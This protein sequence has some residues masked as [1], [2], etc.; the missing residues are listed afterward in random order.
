MVR[1]GADRRQ[2]AGTLDIDPAATLIYLN[3]RTN[4]DARR[5]C[6]EIVVAG[7]PRNFLIS[8]KS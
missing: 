3:V 4:I 5:R 8:I 6:R 7:Q 1:S 2:D